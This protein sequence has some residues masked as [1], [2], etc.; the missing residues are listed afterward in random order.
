MMEVTYDDI[1]S[2]E[3]LHF[4]GFVAPHCALTDPVSTNHFQMNPDDGYKMRTVPSCPQ[5]SQLALRGLQN[6]PGNALTF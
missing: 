5:I 4:T 1:I 3:E 2:N 6:V